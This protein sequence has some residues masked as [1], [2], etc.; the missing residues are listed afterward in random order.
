MRFK[1][2]PPPADATVLRFA[3]LLGHRFVLVTSNPEGERRASAESNTAAVPLEYGPYIDP[4]VYEQVRFKK[5][6]RRWR[7]VR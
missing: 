3:G 4:A 6:D 7:R 1:R 5:D 2:T